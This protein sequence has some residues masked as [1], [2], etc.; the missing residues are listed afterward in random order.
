MKLVAALLIGLIFGSG[1]VISGMSNPAK[2]INFFDLAGTFDPSL[3]LVMVSALATTFA[4]Y[5]LVFRNR[6]APILNDSFALPS[7]RVIDAPL[8]LGSAGFGVGWG[9]TGFCPGGAVPALGFFDI[10]V[11]IFLAAMLAGMALAR[12]LRNAGVSASA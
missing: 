11:V 1:I 12:G 5:R 10:R 3:L 7:N 9:I 2:V 6:T 4:G 8:V